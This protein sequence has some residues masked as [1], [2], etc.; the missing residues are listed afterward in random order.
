MAEPFYREKRVDCRLEDFALYGFLTHMFR[1]P[2]D[3]F[4]GRA[5]VSIKLI[6]EPKPAK[7]RTVGAR[8]TKMSVRS[9]K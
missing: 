9:R 8:A 2:K 7:S 5:I 3:R 4:R 1:V 6:E